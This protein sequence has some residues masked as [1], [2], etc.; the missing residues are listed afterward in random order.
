M[1]QFF[2]FLPSQQNLAPALTAKGTES[3][4]I[5][6]GVTVLEWTVNLPDLNPVDNLS[7]VVKKMEDIR[8][9]MQM[10]RRALLKQA[11]FPLRG[12]STTG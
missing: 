3:W 8:A 7:A 11:G 10:N 5:D 9:T 12:R 6:C 2:Y 1:T 4:F